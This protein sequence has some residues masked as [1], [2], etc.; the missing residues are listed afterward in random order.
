MW[1]TRPRICRSSARSLAPAPG[2]LLNEQL[3]TA[4]SSRVVIEQAKGVLAHHLTVDMDTAFDLL[5]RYSRHGSMRL[6]DT[7]RQIATG[8]LDPAAIT[9]PIP[10][11]KPPRR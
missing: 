4:L 11:G 5:R 10:V 3:Q 1:S 6:A 8:E 7:A 2:R 9:S